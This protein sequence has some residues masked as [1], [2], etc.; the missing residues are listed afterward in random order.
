MNSSSG[1]FAHNPHI[2]IYNKALKDLNQMRSEF[3]LT[4]S[5]RTRIKVDKASD[6]NPFA[7]LGQLYNE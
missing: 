5:S 7:A 1:Y 2:A 4:P 3:G 6:D